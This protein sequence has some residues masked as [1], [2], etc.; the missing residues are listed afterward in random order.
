MKDIL[1]IPDKS[2][3][4]TFDIL[5]ASDDTGLMLL[6]RIYTQLLTDPDEGYRSGD[7]GFTLLSFLDG[8]NRP[9]DAVMQ[10][11]LSISCS[12]AL[13]MLSKDDREHIQSFTGDCTD[14]IV[15]FTLV[16]TDGTTV[17]GQLNG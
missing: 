16:L 9:A 10:T 4:V 8:A 15:T 1:M 7:G 6:Q 13:S 3:H 11:Y 17:K 2:G 14:G 12:T 5:G